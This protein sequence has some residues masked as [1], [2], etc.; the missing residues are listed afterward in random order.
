M[1]NAVK[2]GDQKNSTTKVLKKRRFMWKIVGFSSCSKTCGGGVKTPVIRCVREAPTRVFSP[3]RCAHLKQPELNEHALKCNNKPCPAYWKMGEWSDCNCGNY[4]EEVYRSREVKCVQELTSGIVIQVNSGACVE[5]E[6]PER[7]L[8]ECL[9]QLKT[10]ELEVYKYTPASRKKK[11]DQDKPRIS[12]ISNNTITK[13]EH[14]KKAGV[15]L[16][17]DWTEQCSAVCGVGLQ[18]RS[19]FCDRNASP[20]NERCDLRF[21]PETTRECLSDEKCAFGEWFSGPWSKVG[22]CH[23]S[24]KDCDSIRSILVFR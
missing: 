4:D 8:C 10:P 1:Q 15:W 23:F 5:D 7:E 14:V 24:P 19:I 9:K 3:K 17:S 12:I 18:F 11:K 21:T 2:A 22:S 6:A 20:Q 13:R 16:S